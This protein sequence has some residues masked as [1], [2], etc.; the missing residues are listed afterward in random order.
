MFTL[1][2][3]PFGTVPHYSPPL[4]SPSEVMHTIMR[5]YAKNTSEQFVSRYYTFRN[6]N[7]RSALLSARDMIES[8]G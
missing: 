7:I 3:M 4:Q 6:R 5:T 8:C 2:F 1:S